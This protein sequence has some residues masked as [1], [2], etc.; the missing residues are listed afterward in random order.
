[1]A[2]RPRPGR[3]TVAPADPTE[4]SARL[5][6]LLARVALADQRAFAALYGQ[7]SAHLYAVALRIVRDPAAA[8][9]ILQEAYVSVWH[10][11]GRYDAARS[12]P[13][14][15]LTAIV[16]N[17]CLDQLRRRDLDTVTLTPIDDDAP[18]FDI[19]D[20]GPAPPDLLLQGADAH[21]VRAC[22]ETLDPGPRQAIALAFFQG[23][24]HAEL[25][26]HLRQPLG[27]IKSWVRRALERLKRC[28]D[29]A[30]LVR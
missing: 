8:E 24:S 14:T 11:A 16:R 23:M 30:G 15:W 3:L 27:T 25:A 26:E 7:T 19:A 5:A 12:Q 21:A 20:E 18:A 13:I 10:H 4:R 2:A 9:D 29:G 1:V 28:L 17:R 6:A 22:V